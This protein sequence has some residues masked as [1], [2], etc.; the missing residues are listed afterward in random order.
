MNHWANT[1]SPYGTSGFKSNIVE[2]IWCGKMSERSSI[3]MLKNLASLFVLFVLVTVFM[4]AN[5]TKAELVADGLVGYW[6]L[7]KDTIDGKDVEDVW[8]DNEGTIN[9]DPKEVAGK[10]G[11]ALDFGGQ[12]SVDIPG[13]DSLNFAGKDE[14]TVAAWVNAGSDD[15]VIGVVAGCCGTIVAQRDVN[16][17]ALRYDG[18]NPLNEMEFI[19]CPDWQGDGG[20]GAPRFEVGEWHHLTGVVNV[21]KLLLYLDGELVNETTFAG[22]ISSGG[23]ET[24]IGWA[25]DGGFIGLIDEV[26]IY[27]RALSEEEVKQN[28]E[29]KGFAVD[30][31]GKLAICWGEIK[32]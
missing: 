16:G 7:D 8:G 5:V 21:N 6:P 20:F 10:V 23:S 4:Y 27:E 19:V 2:L 30:S 26:L 28:F 29:A 31:Y 24:E 32:K 13:T 22:P 3:T 12:D 11:E 17:W 9:G 25:N 18:R 1:I 14:L 15:P